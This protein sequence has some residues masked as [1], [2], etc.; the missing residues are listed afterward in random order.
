MTD[1]LVISGHEFDSRF[2]LGSGKYSYELIDAAVNQA[3]AQII[4]MALRRTQA[5]EKI[6]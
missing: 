6:F 3:E 1:K 5:G 4:T 2:I